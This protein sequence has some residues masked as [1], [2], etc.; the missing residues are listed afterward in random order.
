MHGQDHEHHAA[1]KLKAMQALKSS[2][3]GSRNHPS[4]SLP[5]SSPT[6]CKPALMVNSRR[7]SD[8]CPGNHKATQ[9]ERRKIHYSNIIAG[10]EITEIKYWK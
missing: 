5:P 9:T 3:T 10:N 7:I 6:S 8:A 1:P 4:R 2:G